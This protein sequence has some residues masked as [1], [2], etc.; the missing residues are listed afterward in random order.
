VKN[1]FAVILLLC[2]GNMAKAQNDTMRQVNYRFRKT[3]L[4]TTA[5]TGYTASMTGLYYAWYSNY[6]QSSFHFFNDNNEW[7]QMDK[8][9][10]GSSAYQIGR[11]GYEAMRWAGY[12]EKPSALIGGS[13]GF[14]YLTVIEILDGFS[15]EWGASG[16]DLIANS[17][18][19]MLFIGQQLLWKEQKIMLKYSYHPTPYAV[20]RP[21][22]LGKNH[23]ERWLKDYNG[24][25]YWLSFNLNSLLRN[26]A[27][28][29]DWFCLSVGYS[30]TGMT[31]ATENSLVDHDRPIPWFERNRQIYFSADIDLSKINTKFKGLNMF[32]NVVNFIKIPFPALEYN[33][34]KGLILHPVYF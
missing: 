17:T 5:A 9:G 3:A 24:Q 29:P 21:G 10:H 33:N 14:I 1:I 7:L 31:G 11:I 30:A 27:L 34:K 18:G 23:A 13:A 15:A 28:V 32:L 2:L 19:S 12:D 4:I 20:Y 16:G 6:P 26:K 22:L 8:I 25:T